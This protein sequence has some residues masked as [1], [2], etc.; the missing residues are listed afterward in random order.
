MGET[1]YDYYQES[2]AR[3]GTL[4]DA[5][6]SSGE[7]NLCRVL[8]IYDRVCERQVETRTEQQSNENV[9]LTPFG[10]AF[11]KTVS[12]SE[13][14]LHIPM[15]TNFHGTL[16]RWL[17][18][19]YEPDMDCIVELGS[20]YGRNLFELY[21]NG[22][23]HPVKM[24]AGEITESGRALTRKLADL[25][26]SL[27]IT[28]VPFDFT[29]PDFSFLGGERRKNILFFTRHAIEQVE[30]V[31]EE[32]F[33]GMMGVAEKVTCVHFEPFGFQFKNGTEHHGEI[34]HR[35]EQNAMS[36]GWNRN[37]AET[38]MRLHNADRLRVHYLFKNIIGEDPVNP[39]SIMVWKSPSGGVAP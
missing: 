20:G 14:I 29:R 11:E 7:A 19:F 27:D 24:F 30:Q 6:L 28:V 1:S 35:H 34:S 22:G 17:S 26:G 15:Q 4:F 37:L 13:S 8:H 21:Y 31:S 23:P 38:C 32:L 2:W 10:E 16:A 3:W 36:R 9:G 33:T 5:I 25:D 18:A 12:Q 39:T